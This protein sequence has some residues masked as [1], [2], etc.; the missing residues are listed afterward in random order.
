MN[1][2]RHPASYPS[3]GHGD[4]LAGGGEPPHDGDMD[5]RVSKLEDTMTV[6]RERLATIEEAVKHTSTKDQVESLRADLIKWFVGTAL[7][8]ASLAFTAAKF[9]H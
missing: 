5:R 8:L 3:K 4:G 1:V 6:V 2:V 9:I 7:I